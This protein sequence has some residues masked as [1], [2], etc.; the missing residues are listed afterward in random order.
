MARRRFVQ[1]NGELIEVTN[2]YSSEPRDAARQAG[3]L[4]NDR[5]YQDMGDPRFK[6][7]SEHREYMKTH[8]LS[9]VDDFK[10]HWRQKERERLDIR[11]GVD[12]SRRE[13]IAQ[14]VQKLQQGYKPRLPN[15]IIPK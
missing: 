12:R 13:A 14:A 2:D 1:I 15:S 9:T 6:S 4:W 7:R 5:E 3:I 11:A 8:D 10:G